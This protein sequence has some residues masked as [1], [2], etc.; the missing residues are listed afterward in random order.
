MPEENQ[1]MAV[2][3]VDTPATPQQER[4]YT[5]AEVQ[6]L[7]RKR[8]ERSHQA[9]FNRYGVKDLDELDALH[10]ERSRLKNEFTSMQLKNSE[11][12]KS[13]AF[14]KLN[15]NPERYEDI[16]T[17]YKGTGT[18]FSE[19]NLVEVLKTHPEW[20]RQPEIVPPPQTTINSFG[21]EAHV[22]SPIDESTIAGNLLGVKF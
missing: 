14:L 6:Q 12:A 1:T 10:D 2:N 17:Y 5:K 18:E 19:D 7:M 22:E 15:I 8:V 21:S 4:L 16:N 9:F 3:P 13:N 20:V 11:L